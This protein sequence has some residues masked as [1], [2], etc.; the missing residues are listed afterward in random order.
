MNATAARQQHVAI[1]EHGKIL[2]LAGDHRGALRHYR[3]AMAKTVQAGDPEV[4]FRHYLEC[5]VESLELMGA[6]DE[7]LAYCERAVEHYR[8]LAPAAEQAVLAQRDLAHVHQ[9]RGAVLL[10]LGRRAESREALAEALR[11]QPGTMPLAASLLRW[12]DR[13]LHGDVGRILSEQRHH[14]YF[15]VRADTVDRVRAVALPSKPGF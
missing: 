1:A 7:V 4:F 15:S 9:R 6:F 5:T 11:L 2:A 3:E 10:K 14:G 8:D 12:I 13:N